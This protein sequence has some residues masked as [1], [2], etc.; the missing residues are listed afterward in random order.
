MRLWIISAMLFCAL[1]IDAQGDTATLA[2]DGEVQQRIEDYERRLKRYHNF[3]HSLVPDFLR[4][5]FAGSTGLINVGS[6]WA[7]GS[8][9][10]HETDVMVGYVPKYDKDTHLLTLTLRQTFV[11]WTRRLSAGTVPDGTTVG[12]PSLTFQP[13]SCGIFV[14]SVLDSDYWTRE[15]DRYPGTDYY[16]FS[17]KLRLHIFIGQRYTYHIPRSRRFL[18]RQVSIVWELSTC[19]LYLISKIVNK[20]LHMHD[21]LSLSLGL[22]YDF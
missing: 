6:G 12:H 9:N 5:Q 11:P 3:F 7:Y 20:S 13:L 15:P 14:N 10:Q 18:C 4:V 2:Y 16:S 19:D 8:R 21:I 22:K 17:S 1:T